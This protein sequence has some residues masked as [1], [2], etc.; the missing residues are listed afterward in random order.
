ML[1][2]S[3]RVIF[4]AFLTLSILLRKKLELLKLSVCESVIIKSV[5]AYQSLA[6]LSLLDASC[7]SNFNPVTS[8]Q[9]IWHITFTINKARRSVLPANQ[10]YDCSATR[11]A[12]EGV[13]VGGKIPSALGNSR[14][15][16]KKFKWLSKFGGVLISTHNCEKDSRVSQDK[17]VLTKY[18]QILVDIH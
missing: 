7:N 3:I 14:E 9:Y 10:L 4:L 12:G 6:I 8:D 16:A 15:P 13:M 5:I 18:S 17:L 11:P 2:I 1:K